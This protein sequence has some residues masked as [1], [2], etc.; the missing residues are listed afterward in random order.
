MHSH[1]VYIITRSWLRYLIITLMLKRWFPRMH[2]RNTDYLQFSSEECERKPGRERQGKLGRN[3]VMF[4][5]R[6]A[7]RLHV[8][9][10]CAEPSVRWVRPDLVIAGTVYGG[11]S[12]FASVIGCFDVD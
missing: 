4:G 6:D 8:R 5:L 2:R 9:T 10:G 1:D 7:G 11:L 3:V 12:S